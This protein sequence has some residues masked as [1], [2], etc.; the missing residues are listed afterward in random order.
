MT[1]AADFLSSFNSH[2]RM[3][4]NKVSW[5]GNFLVARGYVLVNGAAHFNLCKN[6]TLPNQPRRL[7]HT[8]YMF[9]HDGRYMHIVG[10]LPWENTLRLSSARSTWANNKG[11]VISLVRDGWLPAFGE[12]ARQGGEN[13]EQFFE[14][15][16]CTSRPSVQR[17]KE[18]QK[19]SLEYVNA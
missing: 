1:K 6:L 2:R 9:D 17:L 18:I 12:F 19:I 5:F 13:V 10:I 4:G 15:P 16:C 11:P 7:R 14:Q 8:I 3:T